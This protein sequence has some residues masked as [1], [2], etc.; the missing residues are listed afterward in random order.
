[1]ENTP[2]LLQVWSAK[3]K[4]ESAQ[5]HQMMPARISL[6]PAKKRAVIGGVNELSGEHIPLLFNKGNVA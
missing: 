2:D 1:L 6:V 5:H 4:R 3:R